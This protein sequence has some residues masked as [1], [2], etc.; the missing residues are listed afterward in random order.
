MLGVILLTWGAVAK[1]YCDRNTY[2]GDSFSCCKSESGWSCCPFQAATCCKGFCCP[3]E[4]PYCD[5]Q[6]YLCSMSPLNYVQATP[7]V[8]ASY[9]LDSEKCFANFLK[10]QTKLAVWV[11]SA[12]ACLENLNGFTNCEYQKVQVSKLVNEFQMKQEILHQRVIVGYL[13]QKELVIVGWEAD[14]WVTLDPAEPLVPVYS[15]QTAYTTSLSF[16]D[17]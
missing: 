7:F 13:D 8:S 16:K 10:C 9:I 14:N 4:Y 12:N 11:A 15:V 3:P 6:N 17:K 2:C 5:N 1:N